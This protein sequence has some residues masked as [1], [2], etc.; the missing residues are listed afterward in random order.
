M[1][2]P[3]DRYIKSPPPADER[4]HFNY[5]E[6]QFNKLENV[7]NKHVITIADNDAAARALVQQEM[8]SRVDGDA[9]Q[10]QYTL[11]VAAE[12]LGSATALVQQE[13]T[14]RTT[15]DSALASQ[16]TTLNASVGTLSGSITNEATLRITADEALGTRID[17]LVLSSGNNAAVIIDEEAQARITADVALGQRIDSVTATMNSNT[18]A[19]TTEQTVRATKDDALASQLFTMSS[20]SS[21]VYIATTAPSSLGRQPGDVWFDSDDGYKPYVWARATPE[22]TS[23]DYGWRDNSNGSYTNSV[24]NYAVY[25]QNIQTLT[26][27]TTSLT[28]NVTTL[29]STVGNSTAGLVKDVSA[30]TTTVG[31]TS[32]GLVKDVT[33]LQSTTAQQRIFRQGTPPSTAT[34]DRKVGDIWFDTSNGNTPYYW[35]GSA[36]VLTTDTT[37]ASQA[38]L[39]TEQQARTTADTALAS[40]MMSA[41]AGTSRVYTSDPGSTGR[42]NGDVWIKPEEQFKQY[43]WYNG[44]WNDN[45]SGQYTQYIGIL[46]NV[47]STSAAAFS[48]ASSAQSAASSAT[49]IAQQANNVASSANTTAGSAVSTANSANDIAALAQSIANGAKDTANAAKSTADGA[50]TTAV[51]AAFKADQVSASVGSPTDPTSATTVYGKINSVSA[52]VATNSTALATRIGSVEASVGSP[53][54]AT[55]ANTAYGKINSNSQAIGNPNDAAGVNTVYGRIKTVEVATATQNSAT[56][57]RVDT[58]EVSLGTVSD[59]GSKSTA[60]GI[61]NGAKSTASSA[62]SKANSV[63]QKIGSSNDSATTNT[64]Y[65]RIASVAAAAATQN[66]VTASRVDSVEA[67]I[68]DATSGLTKEV[69][70][71]VST[72]GNVSSGLVKDVTT[73]QS[74]TSSLTTAIGQQRIY[75]QATQ[76]PTTDRKVGDL[77]INSTDTNKVSYWD[78]SSWVSTSD[79]RLSMITSVYRQATQPTGNIAGDVWF[80]TTG[81]VRY[82]TGTAWVDAS[83]QRLGTIPAIISDTTP[84]SSTGR[85]TGDIWFDTD[86][87]NKQYTWTGSA[88]VDR[89]DGRLKT[90]T[91]VYRQATQPTGAVVGDLWFDTA[92]GNTPYYWSGSAWVVITDTTRAA[93]ASLVTEQQTRSSADS[94]LAK[95]VMT[96]AAGTGRVYTQDIAPNSNVQTGDVWFNTND[97]FKPS[98]YYNGAWRDNTT[99][100]YTQ[101]V[102]QI[103]SVTTT[104][105]A[106]Y[107]NAATADSKAVTADGKAV[108]AQN[109]A[110]TADSKAVTADGKAVAAQNAAST[111]DGKAVAAQS[112]ATS[113]LTMANNVGYEWRVQGTIDGQPAGSIKLAGA[114]KFNTDGTTSTVSKLVID[115]D[116]DINGNLVVNGTISTPKIANNA[117]S[118][119]GYAEGS[120]PSLQLTCRAG[121][122]MVVLVTHGGGGAYNSN[123][124]GTVTAYVNDASIGSQAVFGCLYNIAIFG[125][126]NSWA[127]GWTVPATTLL[128]LYTVPS[129]GTYTFSSSSNLTGTLKILVTELAK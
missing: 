23:G 109:A 12:T 78:G 40:Y 32:S 122:R 10:A 42:Q 99:G 81:K 107:N 14:A 106:A 9:A 34:A 39:T 101:Y 68:G 95:Y 89:S 49:T 72:V 36:W 74:T 69:N 92:N 17:N 22:A 110:S 123:P 100:A 58:V 2:T 113:A 98:V 16:I 18:A 66:S 71:V 88:W 45:S 103:A 120:S 63:D 24:G 82:Y 129:D 85:V 90:I 31:N 62:E 126:T 48:T 55:T 3:L 108:A 41:S 4:S 21:R 127:G 86:D 53:S 119:N 54:D 67:K 30:L 116:C 91:K 115:A 61:A 121:A 6:E 15:A 47:S 84:P 87:N 8:T 51:A 19:I 102:G 37:R 96:A 93:Q 44:Q 76:P 83:D 50:N 97:N 80:D 128:C 104:A 70:A 43:V 57:S 29:Q 65:G 73:L 33:T 11:T 118:N 111:A 35:N 94:A 59:T 56:A 38:S 28:N 125:A 77:W 114:K 60:F 75:R 1:A 79:T 20:G 7:S 27:S 52:V 13:A 112:T 46:A 117:V 64:V 124:N 25:A 26:N 5:L 105:T